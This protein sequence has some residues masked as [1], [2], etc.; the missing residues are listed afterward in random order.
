MAPFYHR[1]KS[2]FIRQ[3]WANLVGFVTLSFGKKEQA[4]WASK[5]S[6]DIIN[7]AK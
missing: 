5:N 2:F 6:D 3:I 4:Q 7:N 1:I